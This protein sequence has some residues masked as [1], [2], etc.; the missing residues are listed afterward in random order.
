M[1]IAISPWETVGKRSTRSFSFTLG[2]FVSDVIVLLRTDLDPC[3][4]RTEAQALIFFRQ[5]KLPEQSG[6]N[7]PASTIVDSHGHRFIF[8]HELERTL[9]HT[10]CT[11]AELRPEAVEVFVS[12]TCGK[13][14]QTT[15]ISI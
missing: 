14:S 4:T 6:W 2:L 8:I 13:D 1:G 11:S 12:Q 5:A 10:V 3:I 7:L 15:R 9:G